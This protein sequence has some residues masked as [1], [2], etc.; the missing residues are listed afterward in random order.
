M[1]T[2]SAPAKQYDAYTHVELVHWVYSKWSAL[3]HLTLLKELEALV[4]Y[5]IDT[6]FSQQPF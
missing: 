1:R 3:W 2:T 4:Q 5:V 6:A